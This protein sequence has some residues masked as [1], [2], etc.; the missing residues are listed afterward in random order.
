MLHGMREDMD[1]VLKLD[2]AARSRWEV[3]LTYSGLHAVWLYRLA[4]ALY[5]R[6]QRT[7][8]R[9]VSQ[10]ARFLTG[11]EIHP[12][13]I[14]G[15]RLFIDHGAGV[16]IGETVIIGDDVVMYQGVTL[17]GTGKEKGKRHPTIGNHVLLASG[18]KVLGSVM[19]G[20]YAKI[21]AGAVVLR[22]VPAQATV[23]GIPG[24]V[25]SI[26]GRR[27]DELDQTNLPDPVADQCTM[28][29][30]RI[31][32]LERSVMRLEASL[33]KQGEA[34]TGVYHTIQ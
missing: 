7:L 3:W 12:S 2:P 29:Q 31:E 22:S 25:V 28:M 26:G 15:R 21:G 32:Q 27:V 10:F 34:E 14:I 33:R 6:R 9:V 20:D 8:A 23:V 19:I 16:V 13:A 1:H 24:R 18:A 11:I 17:G 30:D 5:T 4:H